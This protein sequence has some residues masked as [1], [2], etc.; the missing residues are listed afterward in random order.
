MLPNGAHCRKVIVKAAVTQ[1]GLPKVV[2]ELQSM[3]NATETPIAA[4]LPLLVKAT[5]GTS[6][7]RNKI[8]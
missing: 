2:R 5:N 7:V 4:V 6:S 3:N 8:K 1:R